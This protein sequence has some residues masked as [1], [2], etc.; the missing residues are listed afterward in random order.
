MVLIPKGN[1]CIDNSFDSVCITW[2]LQK[3]ILYSREYLSQ[4]SCW[5]SHAVHRETDNIVVAAEFLLAGNPPVPAPYCPPSFPLYC[6]SFLFSPNY[7]LCFQTHCNQGSTCVNRNCKSYPI[8]IS[9]PQ[10]YADSSIPTAA[11][12][13]LL[14]LLLNQPQIVSLATAR[15]KVTR[16]KEAKH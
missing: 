4:P 12:R 3:V 14:N 5:Q 11:P 13:E 15:H 1:I 7:N 10:L 8:R 2:L 6:L 16:A 9:L